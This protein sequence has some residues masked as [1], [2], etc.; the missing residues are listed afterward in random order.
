MRVMPVSLDATI[1]IGAAGAPTIVSAPGIQSITRL[2]AGTYRIQLQDSYNKL[3][4]MESCIQSPPTGAAV[5]GGSFV[6]GTV[7]QIASLGN[8]TA[9]Q[10]YAAGLPTNLTPA[11]GQVFK[12]AT[13]GA[14]TGTVQAI[15]QSGGYN[16]ELVGSAKS[17]LASNN[18]IANN[19]GY[20]VI[21]CLGPTAAGN[22]APIPVDPAN[23]STLFL[24][25]YLSN[26]SIQ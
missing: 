4:A 9:A 13:V 7:Y 22:T 26:S 14:G 6:V 20:I 24:E 1:S 2:S 21:Q 17:M 15:G 12:A 16:I 5:A 10:F 18:P 23:G 19:G 25:I 11:V 3:L 8:T